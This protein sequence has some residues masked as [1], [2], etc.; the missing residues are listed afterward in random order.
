[1]SQTSLTFFHGPGI[2]EPL[3][4]EDNNGV[5]RYFHADLLGSVAASTTATGTIAATTEYDTWGNLSGSAQAYAFTGREWDAEIGLYYYRARYYDPRVGRFVGED[6]IG[7]R[8]GD[9]NLY[10]YVRS[11]P[12]RYL[13][14]FGES[15]YDPGT[16]G[17]TA[18]AW[19]LAFAQAVNAAIGAG[20]G[21]VVQTPP[22][23]PVTQVVKT[24]GQA[25][26]KTK[27]GI[28]G[29][30]GAGGGLPP[31]GRGTGG[32]GGAGALLCVLDP[33]LCQ[34]AGAAM[35]NWLRYTNWLRCLVTGEPPP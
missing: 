21:N 33:D 23:P 8:G 19:A 7:S 28:G 18:R 22:A 4:Q 14:P 13:D 17:T 3:G 10:A 2:D 35:A 12:A 24:L 31:G 29:P 5:L 16:W 1:V 9:L 30:P 6:P 25:A 27:G 26:N 34:R 11:N 32:A 20:K 15:W